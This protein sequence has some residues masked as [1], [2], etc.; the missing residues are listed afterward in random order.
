MKKIFLLALLMI[1]FNTF[2][3]YSQ[4][5]SD[6]TISKTTKSNI[7]NG[8][9][10]GWVFDR[11][12]K[13]PLRYTNIYVLHKHTGTI[14]NE[15]GHFL[16]N[17]YRLKKN[18]TL[19]FQYIGYK[20]KNLTIGQ[21]DTMSAVY[22]KEEI[23]SLNETVVFGNAPNPEKIVKKVLENKD[24]NYREKTWVWKTF[25]RIRNTDD[26]DKLTLDYKKS[27]IPELDREM[28][29]K[30]EKEIPRHT[31][32]YT[33]FLGKIYLPENKNDTLKTDPIRT[34]VLK[35]ENMGEMVQL[36]EIF[37]NIFTGT[38]HNEYWKIKSGIFGGKLDL[39]KEDTIPEKDTLST[40]KRK[41]EYFSKTLYYDLR[42][43]WLSNKHDWEFLYNTGRYKYTLVGGTQVNGEEVYIIDF[44]PDKRG[45]YEGRLY[46]SANTY[47]LIRADYEYAPG[48]T[49][50][51]FHLLGVGYTENEFEGSIYFEKRNDN[52]VLKYF[53]KKV[54][55]VVSFDRNLAL[56]KKRKRF[57]F[58]KKLKELKIGAKVEVTSE[59]SVELLVLDEKEITPKRFADFK[60]KKQMDIIY[61]D[62][63]NDKLWKGFPI[64]EPTKQMREYKKQNI[65][66]NK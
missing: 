52:Y 43:S 56:L 21:L 25:L 63:F 49:G 3:A 40:N 5:I 65:N 61:V 42:Y 17:I 41:L 66:I 34:V 33:D 12:T 37:R 31:V 19:R 51:D 62:Q 14:S 32:S 9:L 29:A 15:K 20:T 7:S 26:I 59:S 57:L 11:N 2:T 45:R 64:I 24:S 39:G 55:S 22:L 13:E 10:K 53:S 50:T 4:T 47:A 27:T 38:G 54:G 6:T 16:I 35:E 60:Q 44:V 18:D 8:E 48:K 58:D 36:E 30:A 46:I 28:I 1:G 23:F